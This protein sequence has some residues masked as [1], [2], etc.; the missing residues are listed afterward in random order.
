MFLPPSHVHKVEALNVSGFAFEEFRATF[1]NHL[2]IPRRSRRKI[3]SQ[4]G[5][6]GKMD[7]QLGC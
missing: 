2:D 6:P 4:S 1:K 5:Q 3:E 7:L